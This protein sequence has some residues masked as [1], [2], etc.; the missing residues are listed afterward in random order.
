MDVSVIWGFISVE[1]KSIFSQDLRNGYKL[2]DNSIKLCQSVSILEII[3][4][5]IGFTK[6]DWSSPLV[7]VH[8]GKL[9]E[10]TEKIKVNLLA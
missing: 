3:H 2:V 6:G 8:Q 7:Q 4:P 10:F 1:S 5:L 9:Y